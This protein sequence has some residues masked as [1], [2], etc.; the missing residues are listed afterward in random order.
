VGARFCPG[1]GSPLGGVEPVRRSRKIVTALFC[2]VAGSTALGEQVDPE[3]FDRILGRYF[4]V[5]RET[6][7]RHG[8]SVEKFIGDAVMAVFGVPRVHEDD[9][10]R[11]VR[12]AAEIR[13]R[14]PAVAAETGFELSFRTGV[15]TGRV[16]MAAGENSVLGD[17]INVAARLEQAAAPGEILLGDETLRL[18]RD[19]VRVEPLDPLRLKGKSEPVPAYRL[20][21]VEPV[22]PGVSR[23]FDVAL[24]DRKRELLLL[25]EIWERSVRESSCHLFT[26]IGDAGVGKSRLVAE[27]LSRLGDR[28]TVLAGRCLHYGE[29]ITFWP[30]VE[31]LSTVGA[32]A[33]QVVARLSSGTAARPEELFWDVRELLESLGRERP[34]LVHVDD[35]QWAEPLLLDL[36]EHAADLARGSPILVLCTARTGL[37]EFRP[38]WGA[39]RSNATAVLL[40]PFGPADSRAL[41]ERLGDQLDPVER[42]RL[43]TAGDG[44]PLFLLEM[45]AVARERGTA[46]MPLTIQALLA[47]RIEHLDVDERE[48]LELGAVE[49]EVFHRDA[50]AAIASPRLAPRL[51]AVLGALVRKE[52]IRPHPPAI[53][54]EE[55]FRFRHIL[56]RDAAYDLLAKATRAEVHRGFADWLEENATDFVDFVELAGWHQ[57][58]AIRYT[59][60]LGERADPE[61]GARAA[62]HLHLAGRLASRR[63]DA[64]GARNLLERALELAPA[65]DSLRALIAIDLAAELL[66]L[67]EQG[68]VDEL[69][70]GCESDPEVAA[71]AALLRLEWQAS[72]G[73]TPLAEI[74]PRLNALLAELAATGDEDGLARAH[75]LGY[76]CQWVRSHAAAAGREARLAAEHAERA[77]DEGLRARALAFYITTMIFG[78]AHVH[79]FA[80]E[81]EWVAS[82]GRGSILSCVVE[83]GRSTIARLEGRLVDARRHAEAARDAGRSLGAW[84]EA[85][86]WDAIREVE[87]LEGNLDAA[88][89]ALQ[90]CDAIFER[91]GE[92]ALRSTVLARIADLHAT[93]GDREAAHEAIARSEE[94]SAAED[95]VN[96]ALTDGARARLAL[97]DGEA[98]AATRWAASAVGHAFS[99]EFPWWQTYAKLGQAEAL[100][101][102]GRREEA[103]EAAREAIAVCAARGDRPWRERAQALL[104][105]L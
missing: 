25:Q 85:G 46:E 105:E 89:A 63:A 53:S 93:R 51:D 103:I 20:L 58:Q 1:C 15:N 34:V 36:L 47:A 27:L 99:A 22:S 80:R 28:V 96:F 87:T 4:E 8:G 104:D 72:T 13:D 45:A 21:S 73:T 83:W 65:G 42:A 9:A 91:T 26:M 41:L 29:G 100:A 76:R 16:L 59:S 79:E 57:E 77:G 31:A 12:A 14:L 84:L 40:E 66:L 44:N 39:G 98:E 94:L 7:E 95:A 101:A 37:F 56:I 60:E 38:G 92:S 2:D 48:L 17:A 97:R 10:L 35:L 70:T 102:V 64:A 55:A 67:G 5:M 11:A 50:I 24:V 33:Q 81:L 74:E 19:A 90:R 62:H 49:G 6:I 61:L 82:T 43:I 86:G 68:R 32:R 23:H 54:G 18:V 71:R 69:L 52:L 78:P 75:M 88:L 30:I 3:I